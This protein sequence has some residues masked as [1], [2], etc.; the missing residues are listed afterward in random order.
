MAGLLRTGCLIP[1]VVGFGVG[2]VGGSLHYET[3]V[4]HQA[5][6]VSCHHGTTDAGEPE[7]APHSETFYAS[8]HVCH[9]LPLRELLAFASQQVS[10]TTPT[11]IEGLDNPVFAEQTCMECHLSRGRGVIDCE[12]CHQDGGTEIEL[13]ERC[14]VC[15]DDR[16]VM[17]Q[18]EGVHCRDCHV[19]AFQ[20]QQVRLELAKSRKRS[21]RATATEPDDGGTR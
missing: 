20:D 12:R 13:T 16:S 4:D 14:D 10:E 21:Q 1:L 3:A 19:E 6:C 7:D 18:F 11:W 2:I 8:C 15:H 5:L 9:V 17:P